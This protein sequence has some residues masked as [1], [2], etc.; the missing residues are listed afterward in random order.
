MHTASSARSPL[1]AFF[2]SFRNCIVFILGPRRDFMG[3]RKL[4]DAY[5]AY[6]TCSSSSSDLPT[7]QAS[8]PL[9]WTAG[10]SSKRPSRSPKRALS[11]CASLAPHLEAPVLRHIQPL[12]SIES[13]Q[14]TFSSRRRLRSTPSELPGSQELHL[15]CETPRERADVRQ[16]WRNVTGISSDPCH[17]VRSQPLRDLQWALVPLRISLIKL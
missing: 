11:C 6:T 8:L 7:L 10:W 1:A 12:R 5:E 15:V 16:K 13:L 9:R 3:F 14:L 4:D 17:L 2:R